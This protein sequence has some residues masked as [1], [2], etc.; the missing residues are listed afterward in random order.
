MAGAVPERIRFEI[1]NHQA[2]TAVLRNDLEAFEAYT[3]QAIEGVTLLA[4]E[5]R[6][7]E[8]KTAWYKATEAWPRE[9]RIKALGDGIRAADTT[10]REK[11]N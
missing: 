6:L 8:L 7:R 10:R 3:S 2:T 11:A 9:P 5:Q 4:S 1:I